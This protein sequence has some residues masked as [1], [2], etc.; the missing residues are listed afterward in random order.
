MSEAKAQ[1]APPAEGN[2]G[3]V[4]IPGNGGHLRASVSLQQLCEYTTKLRNAIKCTTT[5]H[6]KSTTPN[7]A[8]PASEY[9]Q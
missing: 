7:Y 4:F 9:K 6:R 5:I 3:A 8:H 1:P 2:R